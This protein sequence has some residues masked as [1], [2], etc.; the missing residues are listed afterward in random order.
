MI[1]CDFLDLIDTG[2]LNQVAISQEQQV[3]YLN[4]G[5]T[6]LFSKFDI[7]SKETTLTLTTAIEYTLPADVLVIK[8]VQT[9]GEYNHDYKG[10]IYPLIDPLID[11]N[12]NIDGDFNTVF[13]N[14]LGKLRITNPTVGQELFIQY[15][16]LPA[17]I[18][19][20]D[21]GSTLEIP[22][23]YEH[24]LMLYITYL[25]FMQANGGSEADTNLYLQ[26]YT[27][28]CNELKARAVDT[29]YF[30]ENTKFTKRGFV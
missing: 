4:I 8:Q 18:A 19:I 27:V 14:I 11:L 28:A 2:S 5:L 23:Q 13:T 22:N 15:R 25:G 10:D 30:V 1:I 21:V 24:A 3:N 9:S 12:Q 17:K 20:G 29:N 16:A 26:R 6:E 7:E